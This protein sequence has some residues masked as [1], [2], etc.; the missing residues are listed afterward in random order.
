MNSVFSNYL[1]EQTVII[2]VLMVPYFNRHECKQFM[3][4]KPVKFEYKFWIAAIPLG[5]A[6]QFYLYMGK[7]D[8]FDPDL[9]F[10]ESVVD[11]LMD[12]LS[13]HAGLNYHTITDNFFHYLL[14]QVFNYYVP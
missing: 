4:N 9:G 11:K 10:E 7:D 8:V 3:K 1:P 14:T 13:K 12:N 6:I 2:D 5:Y